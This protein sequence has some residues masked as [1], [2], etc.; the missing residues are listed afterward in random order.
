MNDILFITLW[1]RLIDENMMKRDLRL[2]ARL[3][4]NVIAKM[5]NNGIEFNIPQTSKRVDFIIS[6]YGADEIINMKMSQNEAKYLDEKAKGNSVKY[7]QL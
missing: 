4:T 7:N 6:G 5:I 3:T 1:R 2:K